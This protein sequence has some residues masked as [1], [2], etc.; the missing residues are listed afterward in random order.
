M[1]NFHLSTDRPETQIEEEVA[2][3]VR[4]DSSAI[5]VALD[6]L[7]EIQLL[8]EAAGARVAGAVLSRRSRP[9]SGL[10]IGKGKVE[11]LQ[12]LV[13]STDAT[14]V[15]VD[16]AITPVQERNLAN[17]LKCRV[18]DRTRLILDI[19]ARRASSR[20]GKLQVELAQLKHLSTRLVRGWTHLERQ[21]GGIGLRGPGETQL[22]TDRR[23]IGRRIKTLTQRLE[24]IRTQREVRRKSRKKVPIATVALVGYTNAGKSSLFNRVCGA[25]VPAM[26][27][28]FSTLDT[29]MRR[30]ELPGIGPIILSDTVGFIRDLPH[31][32]VSAFHATLEEVSNASVLLH[33]VDAASKDLDE[34]IA[35]VESVL[36]EIGAGDVPC[37]LVYNKVDLTDDVPGNRTRVNGETDE[38]WLSSL[39]GAGVETLVDSLVDRFRSRRVYGRIRIPASAG[40]L[41]SSVYR[42]MDVLSE[43]YSATGDC[44]LDLGL[45]AGD[46]DW[47][48]SNREFKDEYWQIRPE[49]HHDPAEESNARV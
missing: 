3:L 35:S 14:I 19:F 16:H 41:R 13:A 26:D 4:Q 47:L 48:A 11:E 25:T 34:R 23:L 24:K 49:H 36:T 29:T 18:V 38:V 30:L 33:V 2:V 15:I 1:A 27:M 22:E 46:S 42:R 40:K 8:T 37:I 28:L 39:T 7:E 12:A 21:K 5:K 32:L 10:F 17:V 43:S 44:V 45:S 31:G 6:S 20:E 9:H